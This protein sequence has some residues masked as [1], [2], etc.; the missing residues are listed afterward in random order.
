MSVSNKPWLA[1]RQPSVSWRGAPGDD[2]AAA[3]RHPQA[4]EFDQSMLWVSDEV[5]ALFAPAETTALSLALHVSLVTRRH[6]DLQRASS[7]IC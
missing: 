7:A 2:L 6:I 1:D 5:M 4:R 3:D